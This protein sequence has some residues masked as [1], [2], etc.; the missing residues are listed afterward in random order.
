MGC[1]ASVDSGKA[2]TPSKKDVM[3]PKPLISVSANKEASTDQ[4]SRES[5]SKGSRA[6][7]GDGTPK[8][9]LLNTKSMSPFQKSMSFTLGMLGGVPATSILPPPKLGGQDTSVSAKLDDGAE[10][11]VISRS[12]RF[13]L[14]MSISIQLHRF[15][16]LVICTRSN[17]PTVPSSVYVQTTRKQS[18]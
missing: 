15:L 5:S 9:P 6:A 14:L 13:Q 11:L 2:P 3:P 1:A 12:F 8:D 7:S 4:A 17:N 10:T 16:S 18:F